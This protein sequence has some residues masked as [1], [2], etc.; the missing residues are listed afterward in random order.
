MRGA[1]KL[2]EGSA[3]VSY[4]S[5]FVTNPR[6]NVAYSALYED[7]GTKMPLHSSSWYGA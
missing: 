5:S 7:T 2:A 1:G 4:N 3:V 6:L